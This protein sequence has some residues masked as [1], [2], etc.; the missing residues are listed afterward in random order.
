ML[1]FVLWFSDFSTVIVNFFIHFCVFNRY[2]R[3]HLTQPLLRQSRTGEQ[4]VKKVTQLLDD[5]ALTRED[6]DSVMEVGQFQGKA[7]YMTQV[8]IESL[9]D[10]LCVKFLPANGIV[11][12][13]L[14]KLTLIAYD[15]T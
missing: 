9:L 2:L 15:T 13:R 5:Y 8:R 10:L 11:E 1:G 3:V 4:E 7:N 14:K 12:D 6:F